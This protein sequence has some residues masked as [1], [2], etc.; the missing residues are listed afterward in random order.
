ML[1]CV[2]VSVWGV[3]YVCGVCV[4]LCGVCVLVCLCV[5]LC[6]CVCGSEGELTLVLAFIR[7]SK[8]PFLLSSHS[9][10]CLVLFTLFTVCVVLV[11]VTKP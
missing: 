7:D 6:V 1:V 11:L 5:C 4:C 8:Y 9:V 10:T 2:C 3:W